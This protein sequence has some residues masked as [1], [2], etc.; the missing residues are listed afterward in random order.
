M[1][2]IKD[3]SLW[4]MIAMGMNVVILVMVIVSGVTLNSFDKENVKFRD[5]I[6]Q[7]YLVL[8]D[9]VDSY[10][11]IIADNKDAIDFY[12]KTMKQLSADAEV[13]KQKLD[14]IDA[15]YKPV[16]AKKKGGK[17]AEVSEMTEEQKA[18]RDSIFFAYHNDT[19]KC[20]TSATKKQE[21]TD[22]VAKYEVCKCMAEKQLAPAKKA[23][24]EQVKMLE[25]LNSRVRVV[26]TITFVLLLF[27]IFVFAIWLFL[28]T[29]TIAQITKWENGTAPIWALISWL[30]PV[31]NLFK[32][33][34]IF[35]NLIKET[36]DLLKNKS[37]VSDIKE[38]NHME[39]ISLW[40]GSGLLSAIVFPLILSATFM[41]QSGF[42]F[43]LRPHFAVLLIAML[44]AVFFLLF[45]SYL[46]FNYNKKNKKLSE[47]ASKF[48][49]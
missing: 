26:C 18:E 8:Q 4:G 7:P 12:A 34:S 35:S 25:P 29:R 47:N 36:N 48:E 20:A 46:I 9:S 22:S 15:K 21:L 24:D 44:I 16:A 42:F 2:K 28:N 10:T 6:E 1:K 45:E 49:D 43:Y 41:G 17:K 14:E 33:C 5:S 40:W 37:I 13:Q 31:Y 19:L 3:N 30:I 23:Y 27:K 39:S 38:D 32:P 11:G